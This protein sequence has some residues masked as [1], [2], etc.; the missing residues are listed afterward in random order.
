MNRK[1]KW[2][3]WIDDPFH[4]AFYYFS[5]LKLV[6]MDVLEEGIKPSRITEFWIDKQPKGLNMQQNNK[7]E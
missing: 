1:E 3:E 4:V 6:D 2:K 5:H 7:K